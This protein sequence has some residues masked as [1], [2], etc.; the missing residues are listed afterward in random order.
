MNICMLGRE[1]GADYGGRQSRDEPSATRGLEGLKL[2]FEILG[3]G[4]QWRDRNGE[5]KSIQTGDPLH[6]DTREP[7]RRCIQTI[8]REALRLSFL[9]NCL[10]VDDKVGLLNAPYGNDNMLFSSPSPQTGTLPL[11]ITH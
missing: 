5:P 10:T 11:P 8:A 3:G 9:R 1:T 2:L 7:I 4:F 6:V